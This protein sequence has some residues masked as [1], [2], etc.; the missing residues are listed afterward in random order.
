MAEQ[1][2]QATAA[3]AGRIAIGG[4]LP[5][6]RMG[7]GAMRL[8]GQG[9]WGEHP[10]RA[11]CQ[12]V[13]RR[14]LELGINLID[15]A[16]S[17]GPE[18]SER[19][20]AETLYPYPDDLVI[21]TKGGLVRPG[22]GQWVPNGRPDH[23]RQACEGSLKRLRVDEIDVYQFHRP[24]PKVPFEESIGAL[25]QLKD[26]GKIRHIGLSNVDTGQLARA[27]RLT[28]IVSVQ[29]RYSLSDR[30][31]EPVLV[32]C[33]AQDLPFIPWNPLEIGEL[34]RAGGPVREIADR[35]GATP[36]QVALAWLLH[37]S[38]VMLLIPG[39]SK[40]AH[41]EENVAAAEL[42]LAPSDLKELDQVAQED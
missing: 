9:V 33:S 25:V 24:D 28:P 3:A 15:T 7:F 37:H 12:R 4:D 18:V 30:T 32:A 22:P 29:N 1:S 8:T 26:E 17:Y 13:L 14:A 23:L 38:P 36:G 2:T 11:E 31:S 27:Q 40:V 10:D 41:L 5:V 6:N 39:T 21:A 34:T 16:D 35:V 19:L 20:I 42:E